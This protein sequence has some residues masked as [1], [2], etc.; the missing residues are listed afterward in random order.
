MPKL[1]GI[2]LS[3]TED[4]PDDQ[5]DKVKR[6]T[7]ANGGVYHGKEIT[8]ETTHLIASVDAWKENHQSIRKA[9]ARKGAKI[10]ILTYKWLEDTLS[11]LNKN[12]NTTAKYDLTSRTLKRHIKKKKVAARNGNHDLEASLRHGSVVDLPDDSSALG[13]HAHS[14]ASEQKPKKPAKDSYARIEE[15]AL[16]LDLHTTTFEASMLSRKLPF[17]ARSPSAD[18]K[19]KAT[20]STVTRVASSTA[21]TSCVA[22]SSTE[23]LSYTMSRCVMLIFPTRRSPTEICPRKHLSSTSHQQA[24]LPRTRA[25]HI[26]CHAA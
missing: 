11:G 9:R 4:L 1:K 15:A 19:K 18:I 17:P 12:R 20:I 3:C 13:I 10:K 5:N 6:W 14:K 7:L 16:A 21:S 23:S 26:P 2:I 25:L 24:P 8:S 22:T